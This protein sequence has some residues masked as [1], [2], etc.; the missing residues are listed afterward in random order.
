M[1]FL[2]FKTSSLDEKLSEKAHVKIAN[3]QHSWFDQQNVSAL[4]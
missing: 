1:S 3:A 2:N 4:T